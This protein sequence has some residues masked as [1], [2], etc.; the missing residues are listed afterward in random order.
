MV[1]KFIVDENIGEQLVL[2]LRYTGY[3]VLSVFETARKALSQ[4]CVGYLKNVIW[5][6][7]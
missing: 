6:R 7:F 1:V 5:D 2:L 4:K 3:D